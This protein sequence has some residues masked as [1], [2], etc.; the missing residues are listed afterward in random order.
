LYQVV[1]FVVAVS[2][3]SI[4]LVRV[5]F[6]APAASRVVQFEWPQEIVSFLEMSTNRVNLLYQILN[7]SDT[8]FSKV[9]FDKSVVGQWNTLTVNFAVSSLV[10]EV[11]Y[12]F[13]GWI[14]E[15][16]Q[17]SY[18]LQQFLSCLVNSDEHAVVNL[19]QS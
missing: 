13:S 7:A 3:V 6:V 19:S 16:N 10:N 12:G 11:G 2:P 5:V 4:S 9:L 14:A 15:S 18:S 17:R 1:N 8:E